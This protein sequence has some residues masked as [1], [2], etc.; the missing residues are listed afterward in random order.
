MAGWLDKKSSGKDATLSLG[1]FQDKWDRRWFVLSGDG[2]L[3]YYRR[4][5]DAALGVAAAGSLMCRGGALGRFDDESD[6]LIFTLSTRGR[7]LTARA[8]SDDELSSWMAALGP[9]VGLSAKAP[10]PSAAWHSSH[11]V[12]R[13]GRAVSR[14]ASI[15]SA[16]KRK[17]YQKL[18]KR[19]EAKLAETYA[20]KLKLTVTPDRRMPWVVRV[21][22]HDLVDEVWANVSFEI[23]RAFQKMIEANESEKDDVPDDDSHLPPHSP[24]PSP[25]PSPPGVT[26]P[27]LGDAK[28]SCHTPPPG[29]GSPRSSP[30]LRICG[31]SAED[32]SFHS[33]FHQT[34]YDDLASA[35]DQS[36]LRALPLNEA[37]RS[38]PP[39]NDVPHSPSP[40]PQ[41]PI[42]PTSLQP[43]PTSLQ[44]TVSP[45][46]SPP[47]SFLS[48]ASKAVF[49]AVSHGED[50]VIQLRVDIL[51]GSHFFA[52]NRNTTLPDL[53]VKLILCGASRK[54]KV[55]HRTLQPVWDETLAWKGPEMDLLQS[56]LAVQVYDKH[57]LIA[58]ELIASGTVSLDPLI[59]ANEP[60]ELQA[61]LSPQGKVMLRASYTGM[62]H[63]HP[64]EHGARE[65]KDTSGDVR[66]NAVVT[67]VGARGL[68]P[69]DS[70]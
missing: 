50:A 19:V 22:V 45:P 37:P 11:G 58:D 59:G 23:D 55:Q 9:I 39:L 67:L 60:I 61:D 31:G 13:L 69:A 20:E 36:E 27:D 35:L 63:S 62:T 66:S 56:A 12:G 44:P 28:S 43:L 7:V 42:L 48:Q 2:T 3:S 25:P 57:R 52:A 53:Y 38:P 49:E 8:A 41:S 64:T 30:A 29:R 33:I 10:P 32:P 47:S 34:L 46:A 21:A 5:E 40:L 26:R 70:K 14:P 6:E 16:A 15:M 54:S 65:A 1:N 68:L 51:S 18:Q 24:P 4:E 17:I